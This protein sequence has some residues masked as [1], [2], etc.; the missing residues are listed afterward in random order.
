MTDTEKLQKLA[1]LAR[2]YLDAQEN[3]M[4]A[5]TCI[6]DGYEAAKMNVRVKR[7]NLDAMLEELKD[8]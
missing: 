1:R 2:E 8:G 5:A 3:L 4:V 7:T 6:D